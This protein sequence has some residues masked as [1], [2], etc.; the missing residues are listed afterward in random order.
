MRERVHDIVCVCVEFLALKF[1][2]FLY[3]PRYYNKFYLSDT[4]R[5]GAAHCCTVSVIFVQRSPARALEG[6]TL[7]AC[8]T[9]QGM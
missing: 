5:H 2:L 6:A 3:L 9:W 8:R 1:D 4:V 7:R